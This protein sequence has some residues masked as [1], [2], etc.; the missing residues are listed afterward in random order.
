[1]RRE[2]VFFTGVCRRNR[3]PSI[4]RLS[5][6][7]LK[8]YEVHNQMFF[9]RF[10]ALP[11]NRAPWPYTMGPQHWRKTTRPTH[12]YHDTPRPLFP[13]QNARRQRVFQIPYRQTSGGQTQHTQNQT[14]PPQTARECRPLTERTYYPRRPSRLMHWP[15]EGHSPF[16]SGQ[17]GESWCV[18]G[19]RLAQMTKSGHRLEMMPCNFPQEH[20]RHSH[21]RGGRQGTMG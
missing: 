13:P 7:N 8:L 2:W 12:N 6:Y 20:D 16:R 10:E 19:L 17:S 11:V 21:P 3:T 18:L 14:P 5:M 15:C 1:M 4:P 9:H